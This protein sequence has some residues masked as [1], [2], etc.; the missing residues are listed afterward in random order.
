VAISTQKALE[1]MLELVEIEIDHVNEYRLGGG[2]ERVN[3]TAERMR[4]LTTLQVNLIQ[5]MIEHSTPKKVS[6]N[7]IINGNL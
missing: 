3:E 6:W 5:K 4:K 7:D 2:L 1:S